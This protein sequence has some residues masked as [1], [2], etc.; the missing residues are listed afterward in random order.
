[1]EQASNPL[2][3]PDDQEVDLP[4]LYAFSDGVFAIAI[5]LL[6]L[7]IRFPE[8][9]PNIS[10]QFWP[11]L[12]RV[13]PSILAFAQSF[14]IVGTF[15]VIHHRIF[16]FIKR[17][18]NGLIWLNLLFLLFVAFLP[19]P[20]AIV[21]NYQFAPVTMT[22]YILCVALVGLANL[23]LWRYASHKHR[24]IDA[25]LAPEQIRY[26]TLRASIVPA[27]CVISLGLYFIWPDL[28]YG[29]GYL[30]LGVYFLVGRFFG[31]SHWQSVNS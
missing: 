26:V 31:P 14:L 20:N 21:A 27:V 16:R 7:E 23:L 17:G 18:D 3:S 2:L 24:L 4:R 29:F 19:V 28:V 11:A 12:V 13:S 1:M 30:I 10:T 9:L 25:E 8:E 15:W 6:S 22:F 5:T